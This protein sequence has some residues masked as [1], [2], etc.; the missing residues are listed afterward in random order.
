MARSVLQS[1]V[2]PQPPRSPH[3]GGI[4]GR[5]KHSGFIVQVYGLGFIVYGSRFWVQVRGLR[6]YGLDFEFRVQGVQGAMAVSLGSTGDS[7]F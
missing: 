1:C 4:S 7:R 3:G 6:D 2:V 5:L